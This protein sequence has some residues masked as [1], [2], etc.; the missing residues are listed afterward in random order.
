MEKTPVEI[1]DVEI[2]RSSPEYPK[3]LAEI[4]DS[5]ESLFVKIKKGVPLE[6][7][8]PAAAIVGTRKATSHGESLA[9]A[10]AETLARR[11]LAIVSGLALGIDAA[12]HRGA[13]KAMG[14]TIAVLAGGLDKI[15]PPQNE[16][17]A[18]EILQSGGALISE[19]PPETPP[20][21]QNFLARNRI[22]SGLSFATVVIEAPRISGAIQTARLAAEQGRDVFVFPGG[23]GQSN[24]VG[25]HALIRDGARL[26]TSAAEILEDLGL[27]TERSEPAKAPPTSFS[28][29]EEQNVYSL[30]RQAGRPLAIDKIIEE[31][32]LQ[33]QLVG[34]ALASLTI[35]R[36]IKEERGRYSI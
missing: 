9:S 34:R 32:K 2:K 20:F 19:Y 30:L 15:Y 23:V 8:R 28:S 36:I 7:S 4:P 29:A 25:S 22:I 11:G 14:R 33:P 31:T 1:I 13:L 21:K 12:S 16:R 5:P 6:L 17:L 35:K 10:T 3:L 27:G 18:E 24:Y 26:A